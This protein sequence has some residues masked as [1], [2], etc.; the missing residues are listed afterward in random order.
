MTKQEWEQQMVFEILEFLRSEIYLDLRF[1]RVALEELKPQIKEGIESMGTNGQTLFVPAHKVL[2]LFRSN[3]QFL[4][5]AY[6]HTVLHCVFSHLFI[7]GERD[8]QLWWLACD[9]AVE[10]TIDGLNKPCTKRILSW[11]RQKVYQELEAMKE[12][13]SAAV[14]YDWLLDKKEEALNE[15]WMEFYVDEHAFWPKKEDQNAPLQNEIR[16]RWNKI[17]RQTKM[18]QKR[19]GE[20][21]GEGEQQMLRQMKTKKSRYSYR[22]FLKKFAVLREEIQMNPDEFDLGYYMYGIDTYGNLPLIEP[23][24]TRETKKIREFVVVVD[25]SYSTNGILVENFLKETFQILTEK[26]SFFQ[27]SK[28]HL[29]QCDDKI[30]KE[31]VL[32]SKQEIE[33]V[34]A[35]FELIGGGGTD[36]RPAFAYVNKLVEEGIL[37]NLSGLLYFTDGKGI[38][39]S[40]KPQYPTVFIFNDKSDEEEE[41]KVPPWAMTLKI[42]KE[43]QLKWQR[44]SG[45]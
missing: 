35:N 43:L 28:V 9:I 15:L 42:E 41:S 40:K 3:A 12:G 23:L 24:E 39:P 13:I 18:E 31:Q 14:I 29:I 11:T 2:T 30:Q 38:Y 22:E 44:E 4:E 19:S 33:R 1:F 5:R 37:K 10:H 7:G 25:T 21:T 36:F 20:E 26:D 45:E 17:A 6:L 8:K 32:T 16:N 34:M 27:K